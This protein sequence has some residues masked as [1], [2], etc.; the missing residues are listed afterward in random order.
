MTV[1]ELL[2]DVDAKKVAKLFKATFDAKASTKKIEENINYCKNI[3]GVTKND[4]K[5][6]FVYSLPKSDFGTIMIEEKD[7]L[8][9]V[10]HTPTYSYELSEIK[11]I[12][13]WKV[14]DISRRIYG[15]NYVAATIL[16][17]ML[18]Y[19]E[20]MKDADEKR[21]EIVRSIEKES[22]SGSNGSMLYTEEDL[23]MLFPWM[24][25]PEQSHSDR[26]TAETL[27]E[28]SDIDLEYVRS[29]L[30]LLRT[31]EKELICAG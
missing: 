13:G 6:I 30:K 5:I 26:I 21:K 20:D 19:T 18:F 11:T 1:L 31:K 23:K 4:S 14:S 12:L 27:K 16:F 9:D 8:N 29:V 7:L 28:L 17:Q 22:N 3:F 25:P 24:N 2:T 15:E 10:E